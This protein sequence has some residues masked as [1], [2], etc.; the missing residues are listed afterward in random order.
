MLIDTHAH[1]HFDDYREDLPELLQRADSQG[2]T[3]IVTVGVD[4][5]D[6]A[7][8]VAVARAH[9]NMWSTVGL[10]PHEADKGYE[11]L[12]EIARLASFESVVGIGECGLDYYKSLTSREDQERALR[13]QIELGLENDLAMVFHV[14]DAF[15]DFWRILDDYKTEAL[16]GVVHCF[17]AGVRELDGSL[18]RGLMIALNGIMTFTKDEQQLAAAKKLPLSRMVLETDCPFL[19]PVPLRGKRN[20]PANVALTAKFLAELRGEAY[21]DLAAATTRNA[22]DLFRI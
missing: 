4:E 22:E 2:V 3:K 16:R 13:F 12:E 11:A 17:T 5:L 1:I 19:T 8:A 9:K 6:S 21:E 20:E 18:D 15:G 10:H 7:E 14:R